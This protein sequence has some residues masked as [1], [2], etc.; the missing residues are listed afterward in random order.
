MCEHS[1]RELGFG[2]P[3]HAEVRRTHGEREAK[4]LR[5]SRVARL[6]LGM[7]IVGLLLGMC[8]GQPIEENNPGATPTGAPIC[9][10]FT[11]QRSIAF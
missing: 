11:I 8:R 4:I 5:L 7:T 10:P 9:R 3:V 2:L 6:G 1:D